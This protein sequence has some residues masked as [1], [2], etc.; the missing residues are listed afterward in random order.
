M[1]RIE[2][3]LK[4]PGGVHRE[5]NGEDVKHRLLRTKTSKRLRRQGWTRRRG[6]DSL[7]RIPRDPVERIGC[8]DNSKEDV[9]NL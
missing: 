9:S 6:G 1:T 8:S 3:K 7:G 5:G 2:T 4:A